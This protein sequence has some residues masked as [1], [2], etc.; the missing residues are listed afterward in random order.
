MTCL[1]SKYRNFHNS[2][3]FY[4]HRARERFWF[5]VIMGLSYCIY[6]YSILIKFVD[7]LII[8][9]Y[10]TGYDISIGSYLAKYQISECENVAL[11]LNDTYPLWMLIIH[12]HFMGLILVIMKNS[13]NSNDSKI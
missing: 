6:L 1:S 7:D 12:F 11:N 10:I 8:H 3:T 13:H 5:D 9:I 2:I 4:P